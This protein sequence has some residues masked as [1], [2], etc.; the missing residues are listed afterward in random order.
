MK[1]VTAVAIILS[2]YIEGSV[3]KLLHGVFCVIVN[4][5]L[6]S[7]ILRLSID[8]SKLLPSSL[9]VIFWETFGL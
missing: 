2:G 9:F 8:I 7:D 4:I 5:Q 1:C 6:V 3:E